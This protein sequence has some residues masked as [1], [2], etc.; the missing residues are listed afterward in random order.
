MNFYHECP[1]NFLA[2]HHHHSLWMKMMCLKKLLSEIDTIDQQLLM[3][4]C[5]LQINVAITSHYFYQEILQIHT[6]ISFFVW[7]Q[8][9]GHKIDSSIEGKYI[10]R[11]SPA[12]KF[13]SS[14]N[15]NGFKECHLQYVD[16]CW[17]NKL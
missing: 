2:M 14:Y 5:Q 11:V 6:L 9:M 13:N 1:F 4:L 8:M 16:A 17:Y 15:I 10:Q 3:V 7:L 12:T